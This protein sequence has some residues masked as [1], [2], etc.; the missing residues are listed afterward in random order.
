MGLEIEHT[1][2]RLLGSPTLAK[3][4]RQVDQEEGEVGGIGDRG[5]F[6]I[7]KIL[8]APELLG[9]TEIELNGII[10][11]DKFCLSRYSE[12][13]LTWWRRPMRLREKQD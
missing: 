9:V 8:Q 1:E 7:H 10:T 12:L 3:N 6:D 2:G 5:F 13:Q 4:L 11:N